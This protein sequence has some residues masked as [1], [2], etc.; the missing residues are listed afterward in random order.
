LQNTS[1]DAFIHARH[2]SVSITD[3]K[4]MLQDVCKEIEAGS[5]PSRSHPLSRHLERQMQYRKTAGMHQSQ[6]FRAGACA[7]RNEVNSRSSTPRE[8]FWGAPLRPITVRLCSANTIKS[9]C[10]EV[11]FEEGR[12]ANYGSHFRPPDCRH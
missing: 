3:G 7:L 11:K 2:R 4:L 8:N 1:F 9:L 6:S 12:A 5:I 10:P